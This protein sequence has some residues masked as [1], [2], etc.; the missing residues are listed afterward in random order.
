MKQNA[1]CRT[2]TWN[3]CLFTFMDKL[4]ILKNYKYIFILHMP[5]LYSTN[6]LVMNIIGNQ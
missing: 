6:N 2:S 3:A 1:H 5:C 4:F